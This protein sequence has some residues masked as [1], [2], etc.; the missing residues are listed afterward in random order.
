MDEFP[1]MLV[2]MPGSTQLQDGM[3]STLV[4]A[5]VESHDQAIS[6]GWYEKTEDAKADF[7]AK[8]D[9]LYKAALTGTPVAEPTRAELEQKAT[10]LNI[11]VDKRWS[12]ETLLS[13]IGEALAKAGK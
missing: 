11:K 5:D 10:E 3:Y 9:A 12:D 13:Q 2:R 6:D 1:K 4:V 8:Q 7:A